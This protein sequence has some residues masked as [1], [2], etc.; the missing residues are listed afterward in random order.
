MTNRNFIPAARFHR[1]TK[2]YDPV[3]RLFFGRTF[4]KIAHTIDPRPDITILDVG[5][6]PGNLLVELQKKDETVHLTG[7]DVDPEILSIARKKVGLREVKLFESSA[8][9]LPFKD[10]T[11]DTVVSS[12][13]FH[14][15]NPQEKKKAVGEIYRVLKP[16]GMFWF[17]D[18]TPPTTGF[19]KF[20][21]FVYKYLEEIEGQTDGMISEL[22]SGSGFIDETIHWTSYG[23]ISLVSVK[24]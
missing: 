21:S 10:M 9:D 23:L 6:G 20:L 22:F 3:I 14:H 8:T 24:K 13:A 12:L 15:L 5:C 2:L 18:F 19:G 16:S 17:Y 4:K 11:F 7:L 1:V